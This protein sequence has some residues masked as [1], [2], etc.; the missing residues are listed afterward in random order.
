MKSIV[1]SNA[2]SFEPQPLTTAT[3]SEILTEF[4][5]LFNQTMAN[6]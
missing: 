3:C 2:S 5:Q 1:R 4:F 6:K